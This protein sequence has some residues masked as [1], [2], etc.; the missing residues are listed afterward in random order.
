MTSYT[1]D[2]DGFPLPEYGDQD[3]PELTA[4]EQLEAAETRAQLAGSARERIALELREARARDARVAA[5]LRDA[6]SC[7]ASWCEGRG[8][9]PPAAVGWAQEALQSAAEML[10]GGAA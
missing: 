5:Y 9:V 3:P 10:E 8:D 2:A 1:H 6:A 7:F 4:E